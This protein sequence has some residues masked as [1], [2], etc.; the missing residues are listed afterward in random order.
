V[1]AG[2]KPTTTRSTDLRIT[3]PGAIVEDLLLLNSSLIID[4]DNVTV[5]RVEIQGGSIENAPGSACRNGLLLED[6][7]IVRAPGRPTTMDDPPAI[8]TGGYTARRVKLDG[9]PEGFRVGGRSSGCGDVLI[10]DSFARIVSPDQCGDWHGDGVQG[11]DGPALTIRNVTLEMVE[12]PDCGGTAPFFYPEKQGNTSVDIDGILVRG[13]GFPFRLGMPGRVRGLH[14]VDRSWGYGP[15]DVRCSEITG[16]D[17]RIV[18][19]DPNY[20]PTRVIR[21]QPCNS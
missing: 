12:R 1:P 16:W 13:G 2:W 18:A 17:A 5:R 15:I 19:I 3:T 7:S 11:Y 21:A 8:G 10:Q 6:V 14:I 20:Q 4:A 9:L